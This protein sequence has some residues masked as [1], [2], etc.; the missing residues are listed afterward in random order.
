MRVAG[1]I[2][3]VSAACLVLPSIAHATAV[4]TIDDLTNSVVG[5]VTGTV[6]GVP[7]IVNTTEAIGTL[8][9]SDIHLEYVSAD[10]GVPAPGTTI[11]T[12]YNIFEPGTLAAVLS[13]T[14]SIVL[15]GHSPTAPG[16]ANVSVDLHFRSD[17]ADEILPLALAGGIP[18]TETGSFQ[19]VGSGLSDLIVS[20]RSDV[21]VP[22]PFTLGLFGMG[23]L[24]LGLLRR[25]RA[26]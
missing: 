6:V 11:V 26:A 12:N 8:G 5:S 22:E 16:D 15:T 7:V 13:D 17:S 25:R 1:A 23:A 9:G 10:P 4:V 24:A 19:T 3:V 2:G 20:F 21:E 18:I 14:L